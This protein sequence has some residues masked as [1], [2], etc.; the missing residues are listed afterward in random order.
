LPNG[1]PDVPQLLWLCLWMCK[2]VND[3]L[4]KSDFQHIVQISS[5]NTLHWKIME[6]PKILCTLLHVILGNSFHNSRRMVGMCTV[7]KV[8]SKVS[9]LI[10]L[11]LNL[12]CAAVIEYLRLGNLH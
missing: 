1:I 4:Y 7:H 8:E 5:P 10:P 3:I 9:P 12:I 6:V 11:S 2:A